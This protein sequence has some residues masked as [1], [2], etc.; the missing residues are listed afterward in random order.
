MDPFK[1]NDKKTQS[2]KDFKKSLKQ[3][4]D[5]ER[6]IRNASGYMDKKYIPQ[7]TKD[8]IISDEDKCKMDTQKRQSTSCEASK[9][10][11][12]NELFPWLDEATKCYLKYLGSLAEVKPRLVLEAMDTVIE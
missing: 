12:V 6:T 7:L 11:S 8:K 9:D 5:A 3:I 4:K 2:T 1:P 10:K